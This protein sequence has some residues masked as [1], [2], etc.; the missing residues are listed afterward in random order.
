MRGIMDALG[1]LLEEHEIILK[2]IN[3]L[4]SSVKSIQEG[5]EPKP[6]FFEGILD[7]IKNFADK[8]HHGKEEGVLFPMINDKDVRQAKIVSLFLEDHE[9]GRAFVRALA[10]A[11][12]KNDATGIIK[13]ANGYAN[14][15]PL[16]IKKENAIFPVWI[17]PLSSETKE[18][19]SERFEEIEERVIG[20]GKHEEY[21]NKIEKLKNSL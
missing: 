13:N 9:K 20:L 4:T 10:E 7:V 15:L 16:H 12:G 19:L 8:C 11:V 18:E 14:L 1:T 2:A 5:K 17:N 21:I 3:V 6:K